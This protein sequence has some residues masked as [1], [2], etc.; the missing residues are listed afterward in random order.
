MHI[1]F[2]FLLLVGSI[3][4]IIMK[5]VWL[6]IFPGTETS[7][8]S[9]H[10]VL[11]LTWSDRLG[12]KQIKFSFGGKLRWNNIVMVSNIMFHINPSM[13]SPFSEFQNVKQPQTDQKT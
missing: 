4:E 9:C 2:P 11:M 5:Y 1:T 3:I 13:C 6:W 8:S 7:I 10:R 12:S